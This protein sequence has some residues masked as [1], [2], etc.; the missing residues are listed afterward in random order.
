MPVFFF[1]A[2]VLPKS[3]GEILSGNPQAVDGNYLIDVQGYRRTLFCLSMTTG[4]PIHFINL[5]KDNVF[6][7]ERLVHHFRDKMQKSTAFTKVAI[8]INV[9][10]IL[11]I[12]HF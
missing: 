10:I 2:C 1:Q 3:C 8:N 9:S 7:R 4:N 12:A 11:L 5:V 6:H